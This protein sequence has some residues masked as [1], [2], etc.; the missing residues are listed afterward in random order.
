MQEIIETKSGLRI[1]IELTPEGS[2][3]K[4]LVMLKK[5]YEDLL[6]AIKKSIQEIDNK[7]QK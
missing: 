3:R 4:R 2:E 6:Y 1:K 7:A 5:E